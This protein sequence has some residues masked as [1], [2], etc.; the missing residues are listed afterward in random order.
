[1]C[2]VVIY[3]SISK[4]HYHMV[5]SGGVRACVQV[6]HAIGN[7]VVPAVVTALGAALVAAGV[8]GGG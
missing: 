3:L 1:M 7:A 2:L 8:L 4:R 6:Y 5:L